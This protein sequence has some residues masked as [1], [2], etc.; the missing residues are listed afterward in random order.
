MTN[1]SSKIEFKPAHADDPIRRRPDITLAQQRLDWF[2][3]TSL[4]S[5]LLKTIEYFRKIL[6][7]Q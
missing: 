4:E 3:K 6:N 7:I 2:P 1:S 5:G